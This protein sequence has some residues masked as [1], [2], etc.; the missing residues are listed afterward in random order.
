MWRRLYRR[1]EFQL[2]G[3]ATYL[4]GIASFIREFGLR[5]TIAALREPREENNDGLPPLP[6]PG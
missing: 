3:C 2:R 6:P 5:D 1:A 4:S